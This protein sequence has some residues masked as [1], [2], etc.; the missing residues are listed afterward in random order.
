[1][2]LLTVLRWLPQ[3][4]HFSHCSPLPGLGHRS[5]LFLHIVCTLCRFAKGA[6]EW[7]PCPTFSIPREGRLIE[8]TS[9]EWVE[10]FEHCP[11]VAHLQVGVDRIL[12]FECALTER[13]FFPNLVTL[14]LVGINLESPGHPS[15]G[16]SQSLCV[17][18]C[19]RGCLQAEI[20]VYPFDTSG[21]WNVI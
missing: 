7:I 6:S 16:Q 14:S 21:Y 10:V 17:L 5:R 12:V 19:V 8:W 9:A 1:M 15:N 13:T 2:V 3:H 18:L 20:Q 11:K 4:S